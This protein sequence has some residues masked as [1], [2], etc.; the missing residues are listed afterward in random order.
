MLRSCR[1][2]GLI[3]NRGDAL[4]E[5]HTDDTDATDE[6]G[7]IVLSVGSKA[8]R[9]VILPGLIATLVTAIGVVF[10]L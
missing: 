1:S 9:K 3:L 10:L 8:L 6:Q 7:G 5:W 4:Y 2:C